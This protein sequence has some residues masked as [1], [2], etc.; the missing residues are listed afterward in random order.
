[1]EVWS[2]PYTS[3]LKSPLCLNDSR[4]HQLRIAASIR[5]LSDFERH[6]CSS[7]EPEVGSRRGLERTKGSR[8]LKTET[9]PRLIIVR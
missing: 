5:P 9:E 8:S 1:M 6:S 2:P 3:Q 4:T 7:H